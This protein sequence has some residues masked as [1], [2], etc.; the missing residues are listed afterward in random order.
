MNKTEYLLVEEAQCSTPLYLY[1]LIISFLFH[2]ILV[3]LLLLRAL[4]FSTY[5]I[6]AHTERESGR[7]KGR[8][9]QQDGGL[10]CSV[11]QWVCL[12]H[13]HTIHIHTHTHKQLHIN[14]PALL[15]VSLGPNC[16]KSA[17]IDRRVHFLPLGLG[18]FCLVVLPCPFLPR[19]AHNNTSPPRRIHLSLSH[20]C[21]S[22]RKVFR[23]M[24]IFALI[25]SISGF[26]FWC[27]LYAVPAPAPG[28]AHLDD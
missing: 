26:W 3:V 4:Y 20:F 19:G 1:C 5:F 18:L 24:Q 22:C 11:C 23:N 12:L 13:T 16:N 14:V 27:R 8:G 25:I 21:S 9:G 17:S 28:P 2:F 6:C 15:I 10:N 7:G